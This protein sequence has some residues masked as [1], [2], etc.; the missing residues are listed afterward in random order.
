MTTTKHSPWITLLSSG[1]V[2]ALFTFVAGKAWEVLRHHSV[3]PKYVDTAV[4][5]EDHKLFL[6]VRNNSDEP[7]DIVRAK[8]DI[9]APELVSSPALG[10]YPEVTK[11]YDVSATSGSAKLDVVA[12][13]LVVRM[14][15]IQ[16]IAPRGAD[17]FGIAL[18][19]LTGPVDLSKATI[20]AEIDDIKGNVYVV[21]H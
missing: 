5:F 8:I 2:V 9:D 4:R 19:G 10:A 20:H 7:L 14:K 16:A 3:G 12:N 1:L 11:V 21:T 6:F 15:I 18:S 13:H 17:H